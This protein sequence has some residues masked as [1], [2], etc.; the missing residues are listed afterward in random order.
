MIKITCLGNTQRLGIPQKKKNPQA[1]VCIQL[2]TCFNGATI[3]Q[4]TFLSLITLPMVLNHCG[5]CDE[6]FMT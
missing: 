6:Y 4:L 2:N 5:Q 3:L 1:D